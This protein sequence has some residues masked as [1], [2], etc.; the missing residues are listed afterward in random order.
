MSALA[1]IGLA[2]VA[3]AGL[4]HAFN[5]IDGYNGPAGMVA[6]LVSSALAYVALLLS[7]RMVAGTLLALVGATLGFLYWNYPRDLFLPGMVVHICE[8]R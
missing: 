3:I 8:A 4:P 1:G 6:V 5:M 2:F 7:D